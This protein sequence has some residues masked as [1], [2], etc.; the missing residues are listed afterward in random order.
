MQADR[1]LLR[2]ALTN[3]LSNALRYTPPGETITVSTTASADSSTITVAN[4]GTPIPPQHLPFLFDRFYR[5]DAS[6][7]RQIEGSG[8]GLAITKAIVDAHGG[9]LSVESDARS[10]RFS[11]TLKPQ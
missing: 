2:H 7:Q 8:L 3:L 10:T 6:R 9:Q 4:P 1:T 5:A 11:I